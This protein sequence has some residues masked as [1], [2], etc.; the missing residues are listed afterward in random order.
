MKKVK[1]FSIAILMCIS[2]SPINVALGKNN[3]CKHITNKMLTAEFKIGAAIETI[4]SK[5]DEKKINYTI[6]SKGQ[7]IPISV[8]KKESYERLKPIRI[9]FL[10]EVIRENTAIVNEDELL[11]M[12]FDDEYRLSSMVCKSIYTQV[13]LIE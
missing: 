13:R 7:R 12:A 11:T 6:Y 3:P 1:I 8:L 5:L 10:F 9:H 4:V 2:I